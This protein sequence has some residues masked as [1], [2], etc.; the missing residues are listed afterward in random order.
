MDWAWGRTREARWCPRPDSNWH[1]LR[2]RILNPLRLPIS[3][4]G[5]KKRRWHPR[6][7]NDYGMRPKANHVSD[8]HN[9]PLLKECRTMADAAA[10]TYKT[11]EDAIGATPLVRL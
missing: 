10:P 8:C 7:N 6:S 3:S 4:R 2:R 5:R 1:A 9:D 11:L